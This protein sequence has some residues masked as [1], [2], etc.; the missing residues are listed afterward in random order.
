MEFKQAQRMLK[1]TVFIA[2]ALCFE[3]EEN[4]TD[5]QKQD[6]ENEAAAYVA[7]HLENDIDLTKE[8]IIDEFT[9]RGIDSL[10]KGRII[11]GCNFLAAADLMEGTKAHSLLIRKSIKAL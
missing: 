10:E 5:D 9:V 7:Y 11:E 4:P 6:K 2:N 1:A 3:L 8:D